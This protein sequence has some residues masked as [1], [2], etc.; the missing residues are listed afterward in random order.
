MGKSFGEARML[1]LKDK[2]RD[3]EIKRERELK[4]IE[5][6]A[7]SDELVKKVKKIVKK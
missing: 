5:K 3:Q 1:S 4:E 6:V 7:S 2:I